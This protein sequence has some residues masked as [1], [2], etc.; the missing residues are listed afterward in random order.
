V[1]SDAPSPSDI[2]ASGAP[3]HADRLV[4]EGRLSRIVA[5]VLLAE[6]DLMG[7]PF[8]ELAASHLAQQPAPPPAPPAG[9][10]G[11]AGAAGSAAAG[12]A[13]AGGPQG[14][15]EEVP[16]IDERL[17]ALI[18]QAGRDG[19]SDVHLTTGAPPMMRRNGA[20]MA[21]P[22]HAVLTSGEIGRMVA[23][24]LTPAQIHRFEETADLD[25]ALSIPG[26]G[27]VRL[28]TYRQRG[29]VGAA[30]RLIPRDIPE[31]GVLGLPPVVASFADLPR[32][33]VLV[34]GPTGSG[35]STTLASLIDRINRSKQLHIMSC[36]DPIEYLHS[37]KKSIVNQREVGIDTRSFAEA[38]KHVLRQDP[39]VILV[40]EMRDRET[41]GIALSA[42]ETGHL[43]FATLHT[44]SAPS[45]ID[46]I[47][48]VFPAEQQT[49]VR[50]MLANSIQ[51]V[52]T[53]QLL[54]RTDGRG[55]VLATEVMVGTPAIRSLI[56][57][58][59]IHQVHQAMQTGGARFGMMTMDASLALLVRAG[60]ITAEF[61]AE[62]AQNPDDLRTHLGG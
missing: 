11:S 3:A 40:G 18:I 49:T 39:D 33:L 7:V 58:G 54:P 6:S 48:D 2:R 25:A 21:M 35:K 61:A 13:R 62:R 27:R 31:L 47:I 37:H 45:S 22:G 32:G 4:A 60:A 20:V 57:D 26:A 1:L 53:Q 59:K 41:V 29:S 15:A 46:R 17:A 42:A 30:L 51:A 43:V 28:N 56:R 24:S 34:T 19:A 16:P 38:L 44:Q 50:A 23:N 9:S 12:S 36:E 8:A 14:F 5:D 52:L 55:R 10:A